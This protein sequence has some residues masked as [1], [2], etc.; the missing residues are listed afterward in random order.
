MLGHSKVPRR[1]E[2]CVTFAF[3]LR[4]LGWRCGCTLVLVTCPAWF[5]RPVLSSCPEGG[6]LGWPGVLWGLSCGRR[7]LLF[8]CVCSI[9]ISESF[10]KKLV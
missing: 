7:Y 3:E 9:R 6:P 8:V 2:A 10:P 4:V 5:R 1:V